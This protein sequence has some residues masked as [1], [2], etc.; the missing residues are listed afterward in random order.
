MNYLIE[1]EMSEEFDV[2]S[3]LGIQK[4]LKANKGENEMYCNPKEVFSGK[5]VISVK[6]LTKKEA[7]HICTNRTGNKGTRVVAGFVKVTNLL[8][9]KKCMFTCIDTASN[10]AAKYGY[11]VK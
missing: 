6:Q 2:R 11:K 8:N 9:G 3:Y 7:G 10:A 5:G 4:K 1:D